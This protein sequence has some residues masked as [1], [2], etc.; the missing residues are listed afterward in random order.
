M[1]AIWQTWFRYR[2]RLPRCARTSTGSSSISKAIPTEFADA[3]GGLHR[4]NEGWSPPQ[5]ADSLDEQRHGSRDPE[6]E[7]QG[8]PRLVLERAAAEVADERGV[9][10]PR[11]GADGREG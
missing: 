11:E 8:L 1:P 7:E 6:G 4:S 9:A 5:P 10:R 3:V 2:P